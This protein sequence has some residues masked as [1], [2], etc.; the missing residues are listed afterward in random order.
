MDERKNKYIDWDDSVYGTGRT[1]PPKSRGGLVAL[2]LILIPMILAGCNNK[3][4]GETEIFIQS[5]QSPRQTKQILQKLF[6]SLGI[7]D[8]WELNTQRR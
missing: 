1:E 8:M 4:A 7:T 2:L 3:P 5:S 6:M